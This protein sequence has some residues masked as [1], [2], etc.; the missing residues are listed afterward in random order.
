MIRLLNNDDHDQVVRL[1]E[2]DPALNLIMMFDIGE[3][4]ID[5]EGH[6]FQGDYYGVFENSLLQGV[7]CLFNFGS[8]FFYVTEEYLFP[9]LLKHMVGLERKPSYLVTRADWGKQAL[10]EFKVRGIEPEIIYE[11]HALGLT[12]PSFKPR[13]APGVRFAQPDDLPGLI[14]LHRGFQ[15]ESFNRLTEAD[16]EMGRMA[17]SRMVDSGIAVMEKDG[18]I[19]AKAEALVRTS[20][21]DQVGAVYTEPQY[22]SQGCSGA[23][24]TLLCEQ[25]LKKHKKVILNVAED[26]RP[27]MA[28]YRGLG[29]EWM[30]NTLLAVFS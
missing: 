12:R 6:L 16:E 26:N 1:L 28:V 14:H 21:M 11:Q 17:L 10:A 29:F 18:Q 30:Y 7:S 27:A 24:M 4:G 15:K 2:K 22:R 20:R 9:S 3:Y 5:N 25:S 13:P 19:V 8:L 23:C